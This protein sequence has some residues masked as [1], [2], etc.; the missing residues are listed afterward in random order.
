MRWKRMRLTM[1]S[2]FLVTM[3]MTISMSYHGCVIIV[4]GFGKTSNNAKI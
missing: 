2:C 4:T 3:M 1:M